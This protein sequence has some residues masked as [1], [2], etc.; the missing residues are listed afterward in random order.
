MLD[1][2]QLSNF[3]NYREQTLRF[4]SGVNLIV[5]EN[6][7]G[8]TNLLESIHLLS[9]GR[10]LRGHRDVEAILDGESKSEVAGE[11]A[12]SGTELKVVIEQGV[13]KRVFINS[14]SSIRASDLLGRF[15]SVSF[16]NFDLDI[17]RGDS[18]CRRLFMD[19]EL[20]QI[21][22]A[23]LRHLSH[24]KRALE[25]RN[26][27]LRDF[28]GRMPILDLFEPW[29]AQMA[30][31][32]TALRRYRSEFAKELDRR[33]SEIHHQIAEG[34]TLSIAYQAKDEGDLLTSL[35]NRSQDLARRTTTV[36]PHRDDLEITIDG[37]GA[38]HFGSQGQQRTAALS[39]KLTVL[40]F[41]VDILGE[42]PVA[43]LDDVFSE[44]DENR[45][46][47]LLEWVSGTASQTF[48][49]CTEENQAGDQLAKTAKIFRVENG[50]VTEA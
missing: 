19:H 38:R 41:A 37:R 24:Y 31:H 4:E 40:Y 6:A 42:P 13:R 23:Y 21:Y 48:L 47:K 12:G 22:P 3:R 16:S 28:E 45:R 2:L 26:A 49:T 17:V 20:S 8:K 18:S 15:P 5:G 43:L 34:E 7:Q 32:G 30:E 1:L 29:E 14:V 35:S 50:A 11:L 10:L 9:S 36:G 33:G 39:M 27:L 25:Q 46:S 44:L